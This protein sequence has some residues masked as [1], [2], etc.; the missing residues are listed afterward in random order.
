M[1]IRYEFLNYTGD[2]G[3]VI[4]HGHTPHSRVQNLENRINLDTHAYKSGVL[5]A[6][7]LEGEGRRFIDTAEPGA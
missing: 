1:W 6:A 4:V 3:K 7:V 2:F 5:T